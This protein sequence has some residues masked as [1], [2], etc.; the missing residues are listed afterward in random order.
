MFSSKCVENPPLFAT[1]TAPILFLLTIIHDLL[2]N[3]ASQPSPLL[4]CCLLSPSTAVTIVNL[5]HAIPLLRV[6]GSLSQTKPRIFILAKQNKTIFITPLSSANFD[7]I[8]LLPKMCSDIPS[9]LPLRIFVL[10][11]LPKYSSL[12]SLMVHSGT[13]RFSYQ[14][15]LS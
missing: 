8:N 10:L 9:M 6:P 12:E 13:Y 15:N 5:D 1:S 2:H 7:I 4:L 11:P 3:L 14:R